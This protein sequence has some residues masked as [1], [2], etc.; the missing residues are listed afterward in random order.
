MK[1]A[2]RQRQEGHAR[3]HHAVAGRPLQ[4]EAQ[5]E[6]HAVVGEVDADRR[7]PPPTTP[8]GYGTLPKA[9]PDARCAS[10]PP[11]RPPRP[12]SR[13]SGRPAPAGRPSPGGR[14]R[15]PPRPG[16][17]GRRSP[18][19][20]RAG[21]AAASR[22]AGPRARRPGSGPR[23]SRQSG[24]LTRNTQ[25]QPRAPISRP[26]ITGPAAIDTPPAAVHQPTAQA[27][28]LSS[29][30]A[31]WVIRAKEGGT[32][33]AAAA[34]WTA[35]DR[36]SCRASWASPQAADDSA[37]STRPVRKARR[38]PELVAQRPRRQQ[39]RRQQQGVGVD[40]SLQAGGRRLELAADGVQ[41]HVDDGHVQLDD[42][43]AEAGR[44]QDQRRPAGM[45]KAGRDFGHWSWPDLSRERGPML[46]ARVKHPARFAL[47]F[48]VWKPTSPPRR[49]LRSA[50][51]AGRAAQALMDGRRQPAGALAW[52]ARLTAQAAS[53]HLAK[54]VDGGLVSV[55]R[56][57]RHRLLPPGQRRG[58][59][60]RWRPWP[61]WPRR[62]ARWSSRARPR[63]AP[64]ATAAARYGHLAGRL[65]I[66]VADALV[67]ARPD[68]PGRRQA[69]RRSPPAGR[70]WFEDLGLDLERDALK[71]RRGH[72]SAWTGPNAATTWPARSASAC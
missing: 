24:R 18:A 9:P 31:A 50:I 33:R 49:Q 21:P 35:R 5:H 3:L 55:E 7:S 27:R 26:P 71:T 25:R 54:L 10:R 32:S 64:C 43:E 38:G 19:P 12:R 70:A 59:P 48:P 46:H 65:G 45:A 52:A 13:P 56:E 14:L 28:A 40:H 41:G 34:A 42:R 22:A 17:P 6:D 66:A 23:P 11:G 20:G 61:C 1:V 72:A 69:L 53:N 8:C 58:R 4:E 63:P 37:N 60:T 39:Q 2:G 30:A 16:R 68:Q 29:P 36:I 15:S 62:S 57:G 51:S 47:I 44:R 67:A